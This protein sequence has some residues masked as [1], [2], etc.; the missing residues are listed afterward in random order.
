MTLQ[1]GAAPG[2]EGVTDAHIADIAETAAER[3]VQKTFL[4]IGIDLS[5]PIE[6]Q[7]IFAT[8][9]DVAKMAHDAEFRRD[10]EHMRSWR[11]FWES[12]RDKG[13]MAVIGL[14]VTAV[15]AGALWIGF[16]N[17]MK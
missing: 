5:N 9:H 10:L 13:L 17:M 14:L 15:V 4:L 3:A 6:A 16:R 12:V 2:R 1:N 11:K 8:L 7:H